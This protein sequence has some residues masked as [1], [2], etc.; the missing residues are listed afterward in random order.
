MPRTLVLLLAGVSLLFCSCAQP[1]AS[2]PAGPLILISIDGFRWDYLQKYHPPTLSRLATGGVHATRMTPSFPSKTFPNHYTLVTGLRPAHHGIVGNW[3]FDPETGETFGMS[4]P[5]SNTQAR[6][7]HEGEPVWITAEKQ[8]VRSFCYF[9]PGSETEN[10]GV[11]PTRYKPFDAKVATNDRV[12]ELLGWLDVPVTDRPGLCTL[13]FDVVDTQG[14]KFGP[15]APETAAAV[16]QV[17]AAIQRLLDGLARL[18]L[19]DTANLV[20]VSDH[21]MSP[22]PPD[23]V[24]FLEDLIDMKDVQVESTGPVGGVRPKA[25]TMTAEELAARLRAKAPPQLHV[26]LRA[27][28]PERFHYRDNP[29]IPEVVLVCDDHWNFESKVG[30]P[31]RAPTYNLA[32]HGWDPTT[33]NMGALFI[34][35][36]PAFK[37]GVEIPDVPNVDVYN[38]LCAAIRVKPAA[39]DGD[40]AL[41]RAALKR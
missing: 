18:G 24:I 19:A 35:N 10:H 8:G 40:N 28:V 25:N 5:E 17:D 34:A 22:C 26:Y 12:D 14:H 37:R 3:F 16:A 13:Y 27:E 36:G 32:S 39:N 31:K 23:Q 7:W 6:W 38:L 1:A 15:D 33:S 29:R 9:W 11:R 20:L 2:G 21:G 30:W 41:M 4:K